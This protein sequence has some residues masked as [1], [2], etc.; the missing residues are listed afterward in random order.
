M[1]STEEPKKERF[2]PKQPVTLNPPKDDAISREHLAKCDGELPHQ[3][4]GCGDSTERNT[5]GTN[6]G[7]PTLVA[8]KVSHRIP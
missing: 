4:A 6:E 2:A 3:L 5:T 1:S 7:Y 8:I